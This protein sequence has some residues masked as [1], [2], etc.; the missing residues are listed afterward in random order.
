MRDASPEVPVVAVSWV[1]SV[2][3][4][5]VRNAEQARHTGG[6]PQRVWRGDAQQR[7]RRRMLWLCQPVALSVDRA[8]DTLAYDALL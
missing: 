4:C 5:V 3:A 2:V 6:G 1:C 8:A 7:K